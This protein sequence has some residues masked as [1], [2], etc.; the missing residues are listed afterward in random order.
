MIMPIIGLNY[1]AKLGE[2]A[3]WVKKFGN[4]CRAFC[5]SFWERRILHHQ[6]RG[7]E[8]WLAR[9]AH[10]LEVVGSSPTAATH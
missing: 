4:V 9:E 1:S 6:H 5:T 2:K 10:Y 7:V 8:Q 3:R